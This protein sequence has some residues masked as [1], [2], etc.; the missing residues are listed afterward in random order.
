MKFSLRFNNDLPVRDYI[1]LAQ[2]AEAAG[3]DQFWVS[4]DLMLR[5]AFAILPAIATATSRI[6]IGSCIFNPYTGADQAD[7]GHARDDRGA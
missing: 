3:F 7:R 2:A 5:S 1:T 4:N 6:E